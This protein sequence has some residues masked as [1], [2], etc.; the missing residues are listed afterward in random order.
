MAVSLKIYFLQLCSSRLSNFSA[1]QVK[2]RLPIQSLNYRPVN[3][4]KVFLYL[5]KS[6]FSSYSHLI[7]YTFI[8]N[9]H[10]KAFIKSFNMLEMKNKVGR[11]HLTFYAIWPF[12]VNYESVINIII[13]HADWLTKE[14]LE[15]A[16]CLR[17]R[18]RECL[19][20]CTPSSPVRER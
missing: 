14:R 2:L 19:E 11:R 4:L 9:I 18:E 12:A 13:T 8:L 10:W 20:G 16:L 15:C 7:N 1:Q 6:A 17:E 5:I 3:P